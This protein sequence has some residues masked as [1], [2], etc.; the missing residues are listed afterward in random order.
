MLLTVRTNGQPFS[1]EGQSIDAAFAIVDSIEVRCEQMGEP[2]P[3]IEI[4]EDDN[5]GQVFWTNDN[6]N[7]RGLAE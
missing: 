5:G 2:V 3:L 4:T 7:T 1:R 6:E